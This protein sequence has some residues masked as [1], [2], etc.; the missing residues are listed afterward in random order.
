MNTKF[1]V[2]R[3][4]GTLLNY[5]FGAFSASEL[6]VTLPEAKKIA[7]HLIERIEDNLDSNLVLAILTEIRP[8]TFNP[9]H[10]LTPN[11]A[12]IRRARRR[13]QCAS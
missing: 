11:Q 12:R 5:E 9:N 10:R 3:L 8:K 4:V 2:D 6:R 13:A 1:V 7:M